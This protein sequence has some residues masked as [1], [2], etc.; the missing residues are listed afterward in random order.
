MLHLS[1]SEIYHINEEISYSKCHFSHPE[2]EIDKRKLESKKKGTHET[3]LSIKKKKIQKKAT[4][5]KK[6]RFKKK[7]KTT[8]S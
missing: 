4:V 1:N 2:V 3:T 8:R 6:V 7:R 5:K